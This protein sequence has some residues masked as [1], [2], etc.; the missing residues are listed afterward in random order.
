VHLIDRQLRVIA[1]DEAVVL[2]SHDAGLGVG[3]VALRRGLGHGIGIA[4][5]L[6]RFGLERGLGLANLGQPGLAPRQLGRQL[7]A[8]RV[9][10]LLVLS[11][12][13]FVGLG[14]NL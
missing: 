14:K 9:T 1:G 11:G 7:V 13:D 6:A 2:G 8:A 10:E 4:R 5:P 3:E 12:V